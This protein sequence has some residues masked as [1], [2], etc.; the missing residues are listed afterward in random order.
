MEVKIKRRDP[1]PEY[2][3][4]VIDST[5]HLMLLDKYIEI[6]KP[7]MRIEGYSLSYFQLRNQ[8]LIEYFSNGPKEQ[9]SW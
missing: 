5:E 8:T 9:F 4:I 1:N 2:V 6:I 7:I 3:T